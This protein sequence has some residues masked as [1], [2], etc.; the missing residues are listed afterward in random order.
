MSLSMVRGL[1]LVHGDGLDLAGVLAGALAVDDGA[2]GADLGAL[3]A[4]HALCLVDVRYVMRVE[5]DRAP[6][7]DVLAAVRETAAAGV[8]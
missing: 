3:A 7:A 6:A 4:L 2:V 1:V 5:G 8:R